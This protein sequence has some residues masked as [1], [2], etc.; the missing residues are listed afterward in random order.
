M[1]VW[2]DERRG[3][4][5]RT[6]NWSWLLF[7]SWLLLLF[8]QH[9]PREWQQLF[10]NSNGF[11]E[12]WADAK[13]GG[14]LQ[15]SMEGFKHSHFAGSKDNSP[16]S[17]STSRAPATGLKYKMEPSLLVLSS[18][19]SLDNLCFLTSRVQFHTIFRVPIHPAS[20]FAFKYQVLSKLSPGSDWSRRGNCLRSEIIDCK[21]LYSKNFL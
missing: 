16:H 2:G 21:Y 18:S 4:E 10:D 19:M 9:R 8:S 15:G 7:F 17:T 5:C 11:A 20:K 12:S 6:I 3:D 14:R 13:I 1:N